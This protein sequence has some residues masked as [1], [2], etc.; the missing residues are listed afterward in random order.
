MGCWKWFNNALREADITVTPENQM[1]I[2]KVIHEH[3]GEHSKYGQCSA[4]WVSMGKKVRMDEKEKKKL[5]AA[6]RTAIK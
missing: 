2:D 4:E 6:V 1:K 5:I 3:I